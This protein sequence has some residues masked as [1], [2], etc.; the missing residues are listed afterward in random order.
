M[1]KARPVEITSFTPF[2][3]DVS[4]VDDVIAARK[5]FTTDEWVRL[6]LASVGLDAAAFASD[7]VRLL[8]L[9][10]LIPL[11]ESNVNLIELGPRQTGKTFLL[12]NTSPQAFVISGGKATPAN[13]FVNLAT[14][15]VGIIGSRKVVVF[16]E[17]ASTSFEDS[18]ATVSMMKDYMESGQFSRGAKTYSSDASVVLCGNL[19]VEGDQPDDRYRHL[20]EMLPDELVDAAFLDR[21]HGY[22]PGWEIPKITRASLARGP[23]FVID[24]FGE[25]LLQLRRVE[26]RGTVHRL[27][28]NQHLTQ[29]DLVAVERLTAGLA[30]LLYP[31]GEMTE[32][33]LAAISSL[34][35][36]MRQ[37]VHDQLAVLSAGEF[38]HKQIAFQGMVP[39]L[40]ADMNREPDQVQRYDR[41]NDHALVGEVTGLAVLQRGKGGSVQGGDLIVIEVSLVP[42]APGI[43][44]TGGRGKVLKESVRSAYN[45]V[46]SRASELQI[47]SDRLAKHRVLV[48]LVHIAEEREGPSAGVAFVM[49]IVSAV[50]RRPLKPAVAMT[51]EVS[52]HGKVTAVDGV[53]EKV[54]AAHSYGRKVVVIPRDN[55]RDLETL[56]DQLL[57]QIEVFPVETIDEVIEATL[58]KQPL[59]PDG[60][61]PRAQGEE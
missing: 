58:L 5:E 53:A 34:A 51:G 6:M 19:D 46:C 35:V 48:H 42:G 15:N 10:R 27:K 60:D 22:L 59:A 1:D 39:S 8:L 44:I 18:E 11:V 9:A 61:A 40:A 32:S 13:L 47:P 16:D 14:R 57:A 45:L 49:G 52:L 28:F 38:A 23:A 21:L 29:R 30:K 3:A 54:R 12:R 31:D 37:R 56:P 43:E 50:T 36:E 2:Q 17:I 20:F 33:E 41:M 55:A 4:S 7:R 24:F 25:Y 26:M